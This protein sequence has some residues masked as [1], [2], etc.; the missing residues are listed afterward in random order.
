MTSEPP[1]RL[2]AILRMQQQLL[3]QYF[4]WEHFILAPALGSFIWCSY[5]FSAFVCMRKH[6]I[7]IYVVDF[8]TV[9][10]IIPPLGNP[11]KSFVAF[12]LVIDKTYS[13]VKK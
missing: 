5:S 1:E 9:P 2:I 12:I 11:V 13:T 4:L 6:G 8:F 10:A 7:P 3:R